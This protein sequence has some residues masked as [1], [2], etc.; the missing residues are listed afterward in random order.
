MGVKWL[1]NI[2]VN[3]GNI[4]QKGVNA[5][6]NWIRGQTGSGLTE[7]QIAQNDYQTQMANTQ[8]QRGVEDMKSAGLNPAL[9]YGQ[10]ASPAPSPSGAGAT[11]S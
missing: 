8:Y 6:K 1:G 7:A 5:F 3:E 10:G 4:V 2:S 9:M 11:I